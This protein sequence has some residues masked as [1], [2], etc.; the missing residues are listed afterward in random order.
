MPYITDSFLVTEDCTQGRASP[1]LVCRSMEE[2]QAGQD[3]G[4]LRTEEPSV[5][6]GSRALAFQDPETHR[7]L[8]PGPG[9]LQE[10]VC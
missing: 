9:A 1:G 3:V 6:S 7:G 2:R 5:Y 4:L 10:A 8:C